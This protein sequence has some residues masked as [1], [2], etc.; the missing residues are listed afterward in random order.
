M[1]KL[2]AYVYLL[3]RACFINACC[4]AQTDSSYELTRWH[5]AGN[6]VEGSEVTLSN[7]LCLPNNRKYRI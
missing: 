5:S 7:T 1:K 2:F 6:V 4:F 3:I